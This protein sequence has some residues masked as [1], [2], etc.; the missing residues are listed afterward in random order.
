MWHEFRL[1]IQILV[2][3]AQLMGRQQRRL[4]GSRVKRHVGIEVSRHS[5]AAVNTG[6]QAGHRVH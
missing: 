2:L 1:I 6:R 5:T 4:M 3:V